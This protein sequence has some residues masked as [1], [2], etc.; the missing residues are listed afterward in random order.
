MEGCSLSD[1]FPSGPVGTAD[2]SSTATAVESRRQEKKRARKCRGPHA[3]YL[4]GGMNMVGPVDPDRQ[5]V[6]PP[7][8]VP[9]MNS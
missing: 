8:E 1:A 4:D 9:A 7:P 5:T 2:C 6:K 3:T